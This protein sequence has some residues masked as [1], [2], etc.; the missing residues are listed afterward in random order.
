MARG[1]KARSDGRPGELV[2]PGGGHALQAAVS[3][4]AYRQVPVWEEARTHKITCS[5]WLFMDNRSKH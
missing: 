4:V 3:C 5:S 1:Q 2:V